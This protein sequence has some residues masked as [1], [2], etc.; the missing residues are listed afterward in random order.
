MQTISFYLYPNRIDAYTNLGGDWQTE[1]YRR[2][3]N[4]N[5]KLYR[6]VDNRVDLQIKNSDQKSA[7]IGSYDIVFVLVGKETQ[8]FILKKDCQVVDASLGKFIV[9]I[10]EDEIRELEPGFYQYSIIAETRVDN[11]DGTYSVSS[12]RPLYADSQYG[13]EATVEIG[14]DVFGE[15]INSI[16]IKE[17][18][19][20]GAYNETKS[21]ISTLINANPNLTVPQSQ[22]TFQFKMTNYTG[23]VVIEGSQESSAAPKQW[24]PIRTISL[25]EAN[26]HYENL[27]GKFNWFRIK[28]T[29]EGASSIA[30][31][32]IAQTILLDYEVSIGNPGKGYKVGDTIVITGNRLGGESSTNDLTITVEA[33]ETQGIITEISW[34]GVSYNGVRTFALSGYTPGLGSLDTILYR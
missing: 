9:N 15:P 18:A 29:P 5:L 6:G 19:E 34:T 12:R 23:D 16:K 14:G 2:V 1:R 32:T 20:R 22:H 31:F 30:T 33:V 27:E 8:E 11:G 26:S 3:Y 25:S 24:T 17:F 21:Y 4:R 13:S 10:V 28:H 7:N